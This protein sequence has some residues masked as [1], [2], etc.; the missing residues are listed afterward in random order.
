MPTYIF[1]ITLS[2]IPKWTLVDLAQVPSP[3][4]RVRVGAG[5]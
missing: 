4:G 1:Y 3:R 2:K 5:L